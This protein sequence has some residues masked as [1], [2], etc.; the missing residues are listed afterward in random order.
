MNWG[1]AVKGGIGVLVGSFTLGGIITV[2]KSRKETY[3]LCKKTDE[4]V[5]E[6][7]KLV[8]QAQED[9]KELDRIIADMGTEIERIQ[10]DVAKDINETKETHKAIDSLL[11]ELES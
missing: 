3:E 9:Q 6:N 8:K 4:L 10:G 11:E 7:S 5:S 2:L 1:R